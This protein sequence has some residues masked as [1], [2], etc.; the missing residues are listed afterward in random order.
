MM[1]SSILFPRKILTEVEKYI[2]DSGIILL[3]GARQVGKTSILY[4][5]IE[6]LKKKG[7]PDSNIYYFDLEEMTLLDIFN[8]GVK[9]FTAYLKAIG[10]DANERNYIF[11]DEIQYMENPTNFLKLLADHYKNLKLIVSGSSTLEIRKKFK[12]SLAGRKVIF[13]VYPLDF[14]EFL[15]FKKEKKRLCDAL[16][17]SDIRH[18][19]PGTGIEEIPARFFAEDLSR[20]FNEYAVFGGYPAVAMESVHNKKVTYLSDIYN[21]YVKKDIK[22]IMRVDNITAFNNLLKTLALQTGNLVNITELC[23]TVKIARETVERYLFLLENTFIIKMLSPFSSNP[24]KEISKMSKVYFIDTGLRNIIIKNPDNIDERIDRGVLIE[25][26]VFCNMLKNLSSL[27]AIH[28]WRTLAKNEVDFVTVKGNRPMPLEVK[29]TAFKSAKVPS[30]IRHF[31]KVYEPAKSFVLTRDFF[32]RNDKTIF[33]P[34]W[35]C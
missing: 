21:S 24:R 34:F 10:A 26:S 17:K 31:R 25:N 16:A 23:N 2:D 22:D 20:Y 19:S 28:F 3:V 12:D 32:G 30:G 33:M 7:V 13:E 4:L 29:C 8:S 35:L 15:V 14:Y 18:V 27:E 5:L 6:R 11:I 9:E 1:G